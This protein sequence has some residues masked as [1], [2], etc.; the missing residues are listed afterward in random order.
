MHFRN[1]YGGEGSDQMSIIVLVA[2]CIGAS[3]FSGELT[4]LI[5]IVFIAAQSL[6]SYISAGLAKLSSKKWRGGTAVFEI[7]NTGSFGHKTVATI[8]SKKPNISFFLSWSVIVME[9][10]FPIAIFFPQPYITFSFLIWGVVFH[11]FNAFIM[12]LN[13]FFWIF[14]STYPCILFLFLKLHSFIV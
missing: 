6:L 14:L 11:F 4:S 10:L 8:I 7:F 2:L 13:A 12:G 5:S 9:C 1:P 3:F